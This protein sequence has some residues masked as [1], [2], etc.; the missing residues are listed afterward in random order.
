MSGS[1]KK[2]RQ[3]RENLHALEHKVRLLKM[4]LESSEGRARVAE[5]Q[6]QRI[7]ADLRLIV[8][9]V[10]DIEEHSAALPLK[11]EVISSPIPD[12]FHHLH[13]VPFRWDIDSRGTQERIYSTLKRLKIN[14]AT[15]DAVRH[16]VAF[17][18]SH[19]GV[20]TEVKLSDSWFLSV[21]ALKS[22]RVQELMIAEVASGL[23]RR[24]IRE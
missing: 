7:S 17:R 6:V 1:K 21:G 23:V 10:E 13:R 11:T 14:E 8:D 5:D 18:V 24:L 16:C 2:Y 12:E 20:A 3:V 4:S 15:Q 19:D 9:A 22:R